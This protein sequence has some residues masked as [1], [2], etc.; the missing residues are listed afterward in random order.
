MLHSAA[1]LHRGVL[2]G[3]CHCHSVLNVRK[4]DRRQRI[5]CSS[6]A[7]NDPYKILGVPRGADTNTINKALSK[8]KWEAKDNDAM[9]Q[10]L[11]AAHSQ[12]MLSAL[13]ARVKG[14][15]KVSKDILY[16]DREPL[17]PW[18]PKRWDATPKVIMIIGAV[19]MAMAAYAFQSP[20][21]SK[22]V[23][24][25]LIGIAANVMKQN[26]ISPPPKDS[27]TATEEEQGRAGRNF[28]RGALLGLLATFAGVLVFS[29]PEYIVKIGIRL[30]TDIITPGL[31]V[32]LKVAGAALFNWAMTA[33]YY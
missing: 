22:A 10:K 20:N 14:G 5:V 29:F 27:S 15:A 9:L 26:A 1:Q 23:G 8:K 25:M 17:F 30:P 24:S 28:V 31:V 18:K 33:F 32:S 6:A 13:T 11:D 12:L 2:A 7:S 4:L 19:Q 16:A 21:I 3:P